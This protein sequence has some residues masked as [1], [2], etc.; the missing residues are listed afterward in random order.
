MS[1]QAAE[2]VL[3]HVVLL[4]ASLSLLLGLAVLLGWYTHN[5]ALIQ[6]SP[7]FVPMQYN[8][9]LGF[10]FSGAGLLAMALSRARWQYLAAV[11]V[12]LVGVLTLIEYIVEVDLH[13]D[14]LFM[15]HYIGV[16]TS[17]PGRMAP[18]TALC[19]SLTALTLLLGAMIRGRQ[20]LLATT[21]TLGAIVFALG[22][23]AFAGY[24]TGVET[25]YG[26]GAL[27]KMAVHTAVGFM[28]LGV[29]LF[30][31]ALLANTR[32]NQSVGPPQ[33]LTWPI[34]IAGTTLTGTSW[35]AVRSHQLQLALT[36]GEEGSGFAGESLLLFGIFATLGAAWA[37]RG[38]LLASREQ[39]AEVTSRL[40]P[41]AIIVLGVVLASAVYELL[42]TSFQ[43]SV[44]TRFDSAADDH[45]NSI[46]HGLELYV[47]T[48]QTIRSVYSAS[49]FIDR[50]E[51]R[52]V[53]RRD[54]KRFPGI[55]SLQWAPR[56][57]RAQ[58]AELE[59][60]A[61]SLYGLPYHISELDEE[62]QVVAAPQREWYFPVYYLE[63]FAPNQAALGLDIAANPGGM[64]ALSHAL[65]ADSATA[66]RRL[67]L[68]QGEA[69]GYA[70]ILKLP[71]YHHNLPLDTTLQRRAA[72]KGFAVLVL[73]V[74]AMIEGSLKTYLE[75]AGLDLRF[76]DMDAAPEDRLL[77]HHQSRAAS[78]TEP[79]STLQKSIPLVFADR[80]WR[81]V[82]TAAND[83]RY[84]G[85]TF[86]SF[87]LPLTIL[88]IAISLALF[89]R[90]S[91]RREAE[92]NRLLGELADKERHL[93]AL[94]STI[95]GTTWTALLD[96][97]WA[98]ESA[99]TMEFLSQDVEKISGYSAQEFLGPDARDF[100][101]I[102]HPDDRAAF[103]AAIVECVEARSE[104][105]IEFRIVHRDGTIYWVYQRG[106]AE[107]ADSGEPLKMHA[108]FIDISESKANEQAL[109]AAKE[110]AEEATRAKGDFLANMSHEIRTPMNAII[111]MSHLALQTE[112]DSKQRNYID[113]VHRSAESLLGI[114]ND[115]L[116]FSKIEAGKLSMES[117]EFRLEDVFDNLASLVGL[118]AEEKGLELMFDLPVELPYALIGDPLRLG[119]ILINLGNNAVK[120]TDRGEV[121]IR[122]EVVSAVDD[123]LKLHFSVSD[124]GMGISEAQQEQLFQSF[125][126]ADTSTTRKFGGTGLGL[127][128]SKK[129]TDLMGGEIWVESEENK[130]ST[131]HFT[132]LLRAQHSDAPGRLIA[133]TEIGDLRVLVVDDNSSSREILC[134]M[135]ASFGLRV[136]QAANGE[137]ALTQ[138]QQANHSDPFQ[139]VIMDWKMPTMDGIQTTERIQA[140]Q[141]LEALPTVIMV[142]AYGRDEASEAASEVNISSFLT[143]PVTP[144]TLLDALMR[145]MGHK[146]AT[147]TRAGTREEETEAAISALRGARVLLVEDNEINQELALELLSINGMVVTV[148]NNGQEALDLLEKEQFDGVLMDC[149]MP[150]MDG[151]EA[152]RRIRQQDRY[153]NLPVLAMTANAMA[154]DREKVLA[155]GM[156]EH[157]SK[158]INPRELFSAMAKWIT[159]SEPA[160]AA[161][162]S[163]SRG[164]TSEPRTGKAD[165]QP[166]PLLSGIDTR[167]GLATC[168]GNSELYR[169]LL[170][171]FLNAEADFAEKFVAA[172]AADDSTDAIRCAH[173]LKG[174]AGNIGAT[175]VQQAAAA[176]E[177][178]CNEQASS[179]ETE[180]LLDQVVAALNPVLEDL[181]QLEQ[182]PMT[183]AGQEAQPG[184]PDPQRLNSLFARL[185]ELLEDDDAEAADLIEELQSMSATS[186]AEDKITALATAVTDYDFETALAALVE[187]EVDG[188]IS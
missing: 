57:S 125:S 22:V 103:N 45:G 142:T 131:F 97:N 15:E 132:A 35:Q 96:D 105:S 48:L 85:W 138:L 36:L 107:Y 25:A 148:A 180:R 115:I 39:Q 7:S 74:G 56:V 110:I 186:F 182:D 9:A 2:R 58:R 3:H 173:T 159:P 21:G 27:T 179:K 116:D 95:P 170:L 32:D 91:S 49:E 155:V 24:L 88:L 71:V 163:A 144:S 89:I 30:L 104:L 175:A 169:R 72:L 188:G 174:V 120:F 64:E 185:R 67:N 153:K 130:G 84:P 102:V 113:K 122:A 93:N 87:L 123:Q 12:L 92:R 42:H 164:D 147:E 60:G 5:S 98:T 20:R 40:A 28:I 145:S 54:L 80:N 157:I 172:S 6:V 11:P 111:G 46:G 76:E 171:K 73:D 139:L 176:L 117:I 181:A 79:S 166:L 55:I 141:Q 59:S 52:E 183:K 162:N 119:Q 77:Y 70:V 178:A 66:T 152:T 168:A 44:R 187:L 133:A 69:D 118:K 38:N 135:L 158:P 160:D 128:I 86:S 4:L 16:K 154:G 82:A 1:N 140:N 143:K 65:L 167:A 75:P 78:A 83:V 177:L 34:L 37:V 136:E 43:A 106:Q 146:V 47:E 53:T 63:P 112:M 165:D 134:A 29:G 10:A 137:S 100:G 50:Y 19:F 17:H 108:T 109:A 8:T 124:T 23:V 161:V 81:M 129:L 26:W 184:K 101:D 18:N 94:V 121:V 151:Y 127:A 68:V 99:W 150:V 41:W 126:Q 13:I 149:Q 33:W 14:Q 156:N 61:S 51:F 114:I 62:R 31:W 90:Q